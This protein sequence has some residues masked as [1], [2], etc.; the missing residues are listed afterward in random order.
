MEAH[1]NQFYGR[2][3]LLREIADGVLASQ[4]G[5]FS[6]VGTK[7]VGKSML[8]AHLASDEGPLLGDEYA[9]WRPP[10]YQSAGSIIV[11]KLD[12]DWQECHQD[13]LG[14]LSQEVRRRV[15]AADAAGEVDWGRVD[16]QSSP[17]RRIW[18]LARQLGQ[19]GVRLVVLM[20]NFDRVFEEQWIHSDAADELRPLT[21]E[22]AL[23]VSTEQPLHDLDRELAASPLFNV[24]TQVFLGLLETEAA[25]EWMDAYIARYPGLLGVREPLV[26][27]TGTH[28]FLLRRIGDILVETEQYLTPGQTLGAEHYELIRLRLAE[29]GRLLFATLWRKLQ[30]PPARIPA[31][32]VQGLVRRLVAGPLRTSDTPR[33]HFATLNW[34]INQAVVIYSEEG[35][36]LFSPLFADYLL[37]RLATGPS[38]AAG[39]P[40]LPAAGTELPI[41]GQLTRTE[42]ALLRYFL[43][44][45]NQVVTTEQLL[46]D[47][48]RRPDSS[49]RRVQEAIRRLRLALDKADP[50]VGVIEN[51]RGRGYRFA[52]AQETAVS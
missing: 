38:P 36:E 39:A 17:G 7:Y 15:E 21:L 52:P 18:Q 44:N 50:P 41:Y 34:L 1:K 47:V 33:E 28:P 37:N 42:S 8:L 27:L 45:S 30:A 49:A 51:E 13:L 23:I 35:Y 24:M 4:P 6:L 20:D 29:H 46:R 22:M 14:F 3:R 19:A 2:Q 16:A 25:Y 11:A 26:R 9:A 31:S 40:A 12:C 32:V 48:W 10:H 43:A 5:S